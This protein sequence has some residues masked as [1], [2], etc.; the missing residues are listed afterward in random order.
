LI[1]LV[2]LVMGFRSSAGIL[3]WLAAAGILSLLTLALT[4]VAVIP[5]LSAKSVDGAS[6]FA[7]PLIFLPFISSAFV[8]TATMPAAIRAFAEKQPI[9]SIVDTLRSL[10]NSN[11]V[12][13]DIWIALAW[14]VGIAI[15]AYIFAMKT[16]RRIS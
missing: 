5:G 8:P 11:P 3:Q 10:L 16:Y 2:A 14:C 1:I 9:T 13:T 12:G 6:A 15:V 4:W 7:Y